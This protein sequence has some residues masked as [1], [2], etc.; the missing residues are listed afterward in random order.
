[1]KTGLQTLPQTYWLWKDVRSESE[2]RIPKAK[3][4]PQLF[5]EEKFFAIL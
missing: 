1:M 4:I 3:P 2:W 5:M